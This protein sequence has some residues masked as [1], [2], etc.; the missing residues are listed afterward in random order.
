MTNGGAVD[1]SSAKSFNVV[2]PSE[3]T[4]SNKSLYN[5]NNDKGNSQDQE[6][7]SLLITFIIII[8]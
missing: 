8:F 4:S 7:E 3:H 5:T 6:R 2:L 1:E